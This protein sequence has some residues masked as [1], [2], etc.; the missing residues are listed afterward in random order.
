MQKTRKLTKA[1]AG[2][3]SKAEIPQSIRSPNTGFA[4]GT[5]VFFNA[6]TNTCS[7][8][9]GDIEPEATCDEQSF[10]GELAAES[11]SGAEATQKLQKGQRLTKAEAGFSCDPPEK[12]KPYSIYS[13][14][15][16]RLGIRCGTCTYYNRDTESCYPVMGK[17]D[18]Y[19][20][21]K[22]WSPQGQKPNTYTDAL[23][24]SDVVKISGK[25]IPDIENLIEKCPI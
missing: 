13:K 25:Q 4:C 6:K 22:R 5:C 9:E 14:N 15:T 12:F 19:T 1:E 11:L 21:C 20:C 10:N 23:S 16:K 24:G 7:R 18:E 2:Y 8:V 17:L 3:V